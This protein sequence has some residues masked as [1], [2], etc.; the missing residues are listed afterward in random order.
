MP[1]AEFRR[2]LEEIA[3]G[4][5]KDLRVQRAAISALQEAAEAFLVGVFESKS[6]FRII[7]NCIIKSLLIHPRNKPASHT[8]EACHHSAQGHAV[9]RGVQF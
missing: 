2:I 5:S 4:Y 3:A 9:R 8:R 6:G 1:E 7:I